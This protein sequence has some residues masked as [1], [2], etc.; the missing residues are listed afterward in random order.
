LLERGLL[1]GA[2]L[3]DE[4]HAAERGG[5]GEGA[6]VELG[7]GEGVDV[8]GEG[9]QA[10][11]VDRLENAG[12]RGREP[13]LRRRRG[14]D[15]EEE[16]SSRQDR[17]QYSRELSFKDPRHSIDPAAQTGEAETFLAGKLKHLEQARFFPDLGKESRRIMQENA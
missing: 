10:G 12:A 5:V 6:L 9:G 15:G 13:R 16:S 11:V 1:L 3:E 4:N 2:A 8:A 7:T 17:Q 14:G